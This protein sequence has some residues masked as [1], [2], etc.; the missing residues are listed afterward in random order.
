MIK[1]PPSIFNDVI[2]PVMTGPSSSHTAGP[3]R[4]GKL[5]GQLLGNEIKRAE[6]VFETNGSFAMTYKGQGSDRGF[7]GGLMGWE[8]QDPRIPYAYQEAARIGLEGTFSVTDFEAEHPNTVIISLTDSSNESIALKAKSV[9][10]GM[11]EIFEVRGFPV[12]IKGDYYEV[13]AFDS[14]NLN[15][16][17]DMESLFSDMGLNSISSEE[18]NHNG[19]FLLN[20]KLNTEP[21]HKSIEA[22]KSILSPR[23]VKILKPILPVLSLGDYDMPFRN[24]EELLKVAQDKGLSLWEAAILYESARSG[25][26]HDE[27]FNMMKNI[28]EVMEGSII[29]GLKGK[30]GLILKHQSSHFKRALEEERI[31]PLGV[32]N[33]VIMKT[34]SVIEN[35]SSLGVVVAAPTAGSCGV[36]PGSILGTADGLKLSLEEKTKGM[37]AAG[38]VGVLIAEQATFAAEVCGC[39]AECGSASAMAAAGIVQLMG[40]SCKECLDAA[41]IALQNLLGLICDPVA[42]LVE[43]PCLGKNVLASVNALTCANMV[44]GGVDPLIPIDEVIQSMYSVGI[45]LP[46]ELRCTGLGGLSITKTAQEIKAKIQK[47]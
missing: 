4:I 43:V 9:G 12:S 28:V 42:E 19:S 41:S 23:E 29:E 31:L 30:E 7:L 46:R 26:T 1:E 13:L 20:I 15:T 34:M 6:F 33:S 17:E 27:V 35:N 38:I 22:L 21:S 14:V 11:V 8:P 32:L 5:A 36:L 47:Y 45:M 10:G 37:L 18:I 39:Q 2:G 3:T 40:G 16:L 25:W 24:G 44:L